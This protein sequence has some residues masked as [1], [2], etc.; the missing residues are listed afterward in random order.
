[1]HGDNWLKQN[2]S[3]AFAD[4]LACKPDSPIKIERMELLLNQKRRPVNIASVGRFCV[5]RA[6]HF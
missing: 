4:E 2:F 5:T 1:M 6:S 3:G